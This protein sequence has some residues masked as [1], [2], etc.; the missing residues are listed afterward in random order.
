MASKSA[1]ALFLAAALGGLACTQETAGP[2]TYS[3]VAVRV[4]VDVD[5]STTFTPGDVAIADVTVTLT[6]TAGTSADG[7]TNAEGLAQFT[8][9]PDA[10]TATMTGPAPSGSVLATATAV[11]ITAPYEGGSVGAEFRFAYLP[12]TLEGVVFRDED[13]DGQ[14]D[15]AVDTPGAGMAVWLFGGDAVSA[16]T[17]DGQPTGADG[18]FEF[19]TLRPGTYTVSISSPFPTIQIVGD[20]IRTQQVQAAAS[21]DLS[22]QFVGQAVMT[23]AAAKAT[24]GQVV[25]V[26]GVVTVAQGTYRLQGDNM[27]IQDATSGIQVFNV[28]P[29]L[30]LSL[31]DSVRVTGLMGAFGGEQ[32]IVRPDASTPLVVVTLGTGTVPAPRILT[33]AQIIARTFEGELA[34]V[35]AV[36]LTAAP[37]GT[38]GAYN[39]RF[40]GGVSDTITVRIEAGVEPSVPR[41]SWTVDAT[42]TLTG[43]LGSFNGV[44]QLKPRGSGDVVLGAP[45]VITIADAKSRALGDTVTIEGVV[46]V[47]QGTYR[48][49]NVYMRDPTSGIQV[50]NVPVGLGLAVGD[51][52]RVTGLMG[53]FS[54]ELEIVRFDASN[55]PVITNFGPVAPPTPRSVAA[56]DIVART[57]EGELVTIANAMLMVGPGGT[58]GAYNMTFDVGGTSFT[59]RIES[60]VEPSVPRAFWTVGNTYTLTGALGA[61]NSAA[62][63]KPRGPGDIVP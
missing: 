50:F 9:P 52:I 42:Y 61:F 8:V 24:P 45:P 33:T 27:Y 11:S 30:A 15:P 17:L 56:A 51:S 43:T 6:N 26:E 23:I 29:A 58:T 38:A 63:L 14:Y 20:T 53:A 35:A 39:L 2:G 41:G 19:T 55:P 22:V 44:A 48:T 54:G 28:D 49:D 12:G 13:A 46:T 37:T 21:T 36:K 5:G 47:A 60:P 34:S 16:D 4:Y 1:R 31:G 7:T 32:Q 18:T 3:T 57:Y 59:V 40:A 25:S 62:Q 10:Y